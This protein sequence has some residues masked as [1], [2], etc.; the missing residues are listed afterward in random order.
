M[1]LK[2]FKFTIADG[3]V[4]PVELRAIPGDDKWS[5]WDADERYLYDIAW[6]LNSCG[7]PA[8]VEVDEAG[9]K[10]LKVYI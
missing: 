3:T 10:F 8:M 1:V 6:S 2:K 9:K 7:R 5:R 4:V